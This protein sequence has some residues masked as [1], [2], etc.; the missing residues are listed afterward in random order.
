MQETIEETTRVNIILYII[1]GAI[2][3]IKA[4]THCNNTP[5]QNKH[6]VQN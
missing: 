1:H 6:Q 2:H 4:L 5:S 3:L